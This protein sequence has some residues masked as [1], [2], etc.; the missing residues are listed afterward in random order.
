MQTNKQT[1]KSKTV[2]L[3]STDT[4]KLIPR[5]AP[6]TMPNHTHLNLSQ[7]L[8]HARW[9][10][11]CLPVKSFSPVWIMKWYQFQNQGN[12]PAYTEGVQNLASLLISAQGTAYGDRDDLSNWQVPGC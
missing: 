12:L 10:A 11:A 8:P 5:I 4:Q 9:T 1:N 7:I 3:P 6:T 2:P